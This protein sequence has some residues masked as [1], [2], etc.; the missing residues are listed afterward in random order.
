[1]WWELTFDPAEKIIL[2]CAPN[3]IKNGDP[4]DMV[5]NFELKIIE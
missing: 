2:S 4:R 5:K 3:W 1:M